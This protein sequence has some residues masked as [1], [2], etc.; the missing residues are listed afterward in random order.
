MEVPH[1][2]SW[3]TSLSDVN[4]QPQLIL[5]RPPIPLPLAPFLP[6]SPPPPFSLSFSL[7]PSLPPPFPSPSSLSQ[8]PYI[9]EKMLLSVT[10][11]PGISTFGYNKNNKKVGKSAFL[12]SSYF[13][14]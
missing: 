7:S 1:S 2:D 9:K 12:E 4:K 6:L 14:S 11:R 8:L 10:S 3:L 5:Y 13:L